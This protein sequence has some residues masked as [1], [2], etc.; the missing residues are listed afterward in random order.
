M[1]GLR[2]LLVIYLFLLTVVSGGVCRAARDAG[3]FFI[4][5]ELTCC[6]PSPLNWWNLIEVTMLSSQIVTI[7]K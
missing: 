4:T 5:G 2:G 3:Y 6:A 7:T 1:V